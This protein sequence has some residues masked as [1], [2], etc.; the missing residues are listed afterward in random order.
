MRDESGRQ[1]RGEEMG[2]VYV[3]GTCCWMKHRG[4]EWGNEESEAGGAVSMS[5][6]PT[7]RCG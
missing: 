3:G 6:A 2:W 5:R 4:E 7:C 1:S